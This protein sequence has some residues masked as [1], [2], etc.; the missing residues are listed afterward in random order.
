MATDTLLHQIPTYTSS[1]HARKTKISQTRL[2]DVTQH[3]CPAPRHDKQNGGLRVRRTELQS[4]KN[5]PFTLTYSLPNSTASSNMAF[6]LNYQ[7]PNYTVSQDGGLQ[8][9]LS[10][11]R[12]HDVT[13]DG[14]P[15][16][17]HDK[18]H[19][20]LRVRRSQLQSPNKPTIH[21]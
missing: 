12:L 11:T 13:Q 2:H 16:P 7:L 19:G 8:R 3:G 14:D 5:L 17:R 10:N 15:A 6:T 4:P 20:C 1:R 21:N 18:Q 9:K